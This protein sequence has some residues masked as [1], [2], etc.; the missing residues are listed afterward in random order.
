[1]HCSNSTCRGKHLLSVTCSINAL[2]NS[3][4]HYNYIGGVV[5]A[6]RG[7]MVVDL[8]DVAASKDVPLGSKRKLHGL[9][10]R[11]TTV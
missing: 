2:T 9:R 6:M 7:D 8:F 4:L 10:L 5:L 11:G 3:L 1:M